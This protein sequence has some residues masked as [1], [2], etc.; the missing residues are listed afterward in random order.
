[1]KEYYY[2]PESKVTTWDRPKASE[3]PPKEKKSPAQSASASRLTPSKSIAS[4]GVGR[5]GLLADIRKG[6]KLKKVTT[7]ESSPLENVTYVIL[8]FCLSLHMFKQFEF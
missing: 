6:T 5:G 7:R 8:S 3:S 2:N 1:L 4:E